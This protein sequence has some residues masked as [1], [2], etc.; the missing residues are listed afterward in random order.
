[1]SVP[2]AEEIMTFVAA[3]AVRDG[4]VCLV[5]HG[6]P[7]A[8]AHLARRL[9][10][11]AAVVVHESG[12]VDVRLRDDDPLTDATVADRALTHVTLGSLYGEWL[13]AG[14]VDLGF[15]G[16]VPGAQLD[17]YANIGSSVVG[18]Y[19]EPTERL[20]GPGAAAEIAAWA[21]ETVIVVRHR[22]QAFV[23]Q[24]DFVTAV[25]HGTGPLDRALLGLRGRG[26]V[27]VV[28]DLGV[29]EPDPQTAELVLTAVHPGIDV[30]QVRAET[31]WDLQVAPDV[32]T[33][34]EPTG[35]ELAALRTLR[36][37]STEESP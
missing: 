7:A 6:I 3:R 19:D 23:E 37:A 11:P 1:M 13:Q 9:H 8:A 34:P 20:P 12:A 26:P 15:V 31:G 18:E 4:Q 21:G 16:H 22:L 32:R 33:T 10:A 5:G 17:R 25:G 14:R 30:E 2:T 24:V 29:L 35:T 28:T 27:R 36:P